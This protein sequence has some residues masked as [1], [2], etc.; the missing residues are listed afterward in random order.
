MR[1]ATS[2]E[3]TNLYPK[4]ISILA[5]HEGCDLLFSLL[6]ILLPFQSSHP[7]RGAT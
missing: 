1:G 7:M 5:P 6:P 2:A 4:G 3:V